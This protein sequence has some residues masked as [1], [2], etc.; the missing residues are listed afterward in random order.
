[1][2]R[3]QIHILCCPKP[4]TMQEPVTCPC[5]QRDNHVHVPPPPPHPISLQSILILSSNLHLRIPI[6]LIPP[7][8]PTKTLNTSPRKYHK[9][10]TSSTQ[11]L[12]CNRTAKNSEREFKRISTN[13]RNRNCSYYAVCFVRPK[14]V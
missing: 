10:N 14:Q 1:M 7:S 12:Q 3:K 11:F 2:W 13:Y 6:G 9:S 4:T 8:F 5:P